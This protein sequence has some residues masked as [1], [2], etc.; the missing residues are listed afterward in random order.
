M[1]KRRS[2]KDLAGKNGVPAS[3]RSRPRRAHIGD[4]PPA[5][6]QSFLKCMETPRDAATYFVHYGSTGTE[7]LGASN[8]GFVDFLCPRFSGFVVQGCQGWGIGL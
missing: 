5:L 1:G 7:A 4:P 3:K 6:Q 8:V 2:K